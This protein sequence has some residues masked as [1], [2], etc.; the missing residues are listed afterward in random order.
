MRGIFSVKRQGFASILAIV[1]IIAVAAFGA[2]NILKISKTGS[3]QINQNTSTKKILGAYD[4]PHSDLEKYLIVEAALLGVSDNISLYFRDIY[5]SNEVA[6]DPTRSWIPASTI[7]SFVVPEAFRQ[8]RIGL[9][10]FNDTVTIKA[11]NVVPTELET[12]EFPRLREGTQAT[13]GQLVQAMVEQSDNTAYNTLLDVLD[14]RNINLTLKN[15]GITQ[16]V[17]G[18][19]LNLDDDQFSIDLQVPGRQPVT[20]TAEDLATLFKLMYQNNIPD[21]EEML[22]I[23]KNQKI[24]NMIP[25]FLPDN[26]TVAHKTGDWAPIYHDGGIVYKE[27]SPFILSIF[28]NSNDPTVVSKMARVAYQQDAN[29]V[30]LG[31]EKV[32]ENSNEQTSNSRPEYF[33]SEADI[34]STKVL[35][36]KSDKQLPKVTAA[37]LGITSDDLKSNEASSSPIRSAFIDPSSPFY[38]IKK[39]IEDLR[40]KFAT[41]P[42][43]KL[44]IQ[45]NFAQNRLAEFE[46]E[47]KKGNITSAQNLLDQTEQS[48]KQ[49]VVESQSNAESDNNLLRIKQAN[50]TSYSELAKIAQDLPGD[51]KE[52]F[53]NIVYRF[54]QN[55]KREVKPTVNKSLTATRSTNQ[56]PIIGTVVKTTDTSAIVQFDNGTTREIVINDAIPSRDFKNTQADNKLILDVN[57]KVAIVGQAT[58][59]GKIVPQFILKNV[60]KNIPDKRTGIVIDVN[61][62][63][64]TLKILDSSGSQ[65]EV[66]VNNNTSITSSDTNVSLEGIKVGSQITVSG[67]K[68]DSQTQN[69]NQGQNK[70]SPKQESTS[71]TSIVVTKNSSGST[72]KKSSQSNDQHKDQGKNQDK[73]EEQKNTAPPPPPPASSNNDD[74]K[75]EDKK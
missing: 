47:I 22:S 61:P 51:K 25:F 53:V 67:Q 62:N 1:I 42:E 37:D 63:N 46:N 5:S 17:V 14:R 70:N 12:D 58:K 44:N 59:D 71:A 49:S 38:K 55:N 4:E 52:A 40:L 28:T 24:N 11:E 3:A 64:N 41:T 31:N 69:T 50:D 57:S 33:L 9:I 2:F 60:P 66:K 6:I 73:K 7:K 36:E 32:Q 54:V 18:E 43:Q 10:D 74:S 8:R 34:T 27:N 30:G 75:K 68:Q 45:I 23:F 26:V 65:E 72:E 15:L 35:A 21:S 29:A 16:T 48:L 19:K 56:E 20:T 39:L 13:I